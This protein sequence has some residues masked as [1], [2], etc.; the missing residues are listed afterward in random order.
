MIFSEVSNMKDMCFFVF[1]IILIWFQHN[2][3]NDKYNV[4]LKDP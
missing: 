4:F 2:V 3:N 1:D